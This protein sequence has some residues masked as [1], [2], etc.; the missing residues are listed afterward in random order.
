M[1]GFAGFL[2]KDLGFDGSTVLKNM[3]ESLYHRGPDHIELFNHSKLGLGMVHTRLSILDLSNAGI[4]PMHSQNGRYII[5]YNG[6]IYNYK[7][8]REELC[9]IGTRFV[10]SSDTE[11]LIQY[12]EQFGLVTTLN[13]IRGMFAFALFDTHKNQLSLVRDRAGEKPLY[14]SYKNGELIFGSELKPL[15][16]WPN[17]DKALNKEALKQ[18]LLHGFITSGHSIFKDVVKQRPGTMIQFT[19]SQGGWQLSKEFSYWEILGNEQDNLSSQSMCTDYEYINELDNILNS[20]VHEQLASDVPVGAFLS[21]GID[22]SLIV[23]M[24]NKT[25]DSNVDTFSIGFEDKE[26]NEAEHAKAVANFIGTRHHTL[27]VDDKAIMDVIPKLPSVYDE[28]MAD[29]S[30]LPTYLV[31]QFSSEK[32]KVALTGDAG[33]EIFG[34][35]NRYLWANKVN[36]ATRAFPTGVRLF[37][38]K[39]LS[40]VS[41]ATYELLG[42]MLPYKYRVNELGI[43]AHKALR[44]FSAPNNLAMYE[45]ILNQFSSLGMI[46]RHSGFNQVSSTQKHAFEALSSPEQFMVLDFMNYMADGVLCKVD[47]A[48]MANSLETRAPFLD[49]RVIEFGVNLPSGLKIRNNQSKWI[50]RQLLEKYIP[51]ELFERPKM[52]FAVPMGSWLRGSLKDWSFAMLEKHKHRVEDVIEP[53]LLENMWEQHQ[54]GGQN[55]QTQIWTLITFFQWCEEHLD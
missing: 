30:Q 13:N 45:L 1:C 41:P 40:S 43:K 6:E 2:V 39:L 18:F 55:Y 37:L 10:G 51:R 44:S 34:G 3:G 4:Q 42:K 9:S 23:A 12:I 22:S 36:K 47:R 54:T 19:L 32:V 17:F 35:Y 8:L 20:A 52:G 24:M 49:K 48:A 15:L 33:D 27:Y 26:Y 7:E 25:T 14:Y 16:K 29:M 38:A 21:G 11:V 28:P 5:S 53:S 31:S 46:A 50:L